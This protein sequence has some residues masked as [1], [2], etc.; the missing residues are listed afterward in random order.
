MKSI[1]NNCLKQSSTTYMWMGSEIADR[2]HDK[3]WGCSRNFMK[4]KLG[5]QG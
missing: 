2:S 5:A 4:S 3:F 1:L